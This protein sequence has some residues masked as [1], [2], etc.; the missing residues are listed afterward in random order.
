MTTQIRTVSLTLI[1]ANPDNPR[2]S[3]GDLTELAAN[4]K[5]Q[6]IQQPPVIAPTQDGRYIAVIGH[7]RLAAAKDAGLKSTPCIIR[8]YSKRAAAET[9]LVENTQRANLTDLEE[10]DGY[11][12][13][14]DLG[15]TVEQAARKTGRAASTVRRRAR[16]AAIGDE[17]R[18]LF[19]GQPTLGQLETISRYAGRPDLQAGLAKAAGTKNWHYTLNETERRHARDTWWSE[20]LD[21]LRDTPHVEWELPVNGWHAAPTPLEARDERERQRARREAEREA[22]DRRAE[23]FART[24]EA[25]RR[26][27]AEGILNRKRPADRPDRLMSLIRL[28]L[29]L[30]FD[31]GTSWRQQ[32][33][34]RENLHLTS[35]HDDTSD[36]GEDEGA[37]PTLASLLEGQ[38]DARAVAAACIAWHEAAITGRQWQDKETLG[39]RI[40]P[41]YKTL[42]VLGYRPS[43]AETEALTGRYATE[44]E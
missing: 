19:G 34:I 35:T 26:G 44:E 23:T 12:L 29:T 15:E 33:G 42:E 31:E 10:A 11:Q 22:A 14:L 9:M 13:L 30:M 21:P 38:P 7:R 5:A 41:Y 28:T 16:V 6:G 25:T 18:R 36:D 32:N 20:A 8:K 24:A 3:L 1:D 40:A 43:H 37:A 17:T 39:H 4:I 27:F 2:K